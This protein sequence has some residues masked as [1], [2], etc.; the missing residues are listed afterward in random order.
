MVEGSGSRQGQQAVIQR[1]HGMQG[2]AGLGQ[3]VRL[4]VAAEDSRADGRDTEAMTDRDVHSLSPGSAGGQGTGLFPARQRC[5]AMGTAGK[6]KLPS[7]LLTWGCL[8]MGAAHGD[9]DR[10]VSVAAPAQL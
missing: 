10:A 8:L 9:K 7:Q 2:G 4:S 6:A 5:K 3:L 1:A